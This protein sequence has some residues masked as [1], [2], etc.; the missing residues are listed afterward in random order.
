LIFNQY[1]NPIALANI[2]WKC[3]SFPTLPLL[4]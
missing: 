1:A 2:G 4:L 3:T